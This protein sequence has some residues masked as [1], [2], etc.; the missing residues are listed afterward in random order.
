MLVS[1]TTPTFDLSGHVII[2][3]K[4]DVT[5][6]EMRRRVNRVPTL[7]GGVA[8]NDRG[9][10]DGDRDILLTWY[11][12]SQEHSDL[13]ARLVRLYPLLNVSMRDG[14]YIAVPE[15]FVPGVKESTLNLLV[16]S[17]LTP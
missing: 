14:V 1:I 10:S 17:K 4:P 13:V 7:D 9:F 6:G 11:T 2:Q 8:I 15:S 3:T 12:V 16:K 5:T